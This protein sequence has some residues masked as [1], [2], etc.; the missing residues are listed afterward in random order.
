M[1]TRAFNEKQ[2]NAHEHA[3]KR[4]KPNFP[5]IFALLGVR[6][7]CFCFCCRKNR[8]NPFFVA[9]HKK[10]CPRASRR[11]RKPAGPHTENAV[12]GPFVKSTQKNQMVQWK[13]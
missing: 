8:L 11:G 7:R 13:S 3:R 4:G 1:E 10:N 2:D 6:L 5:D 9:S 12:H